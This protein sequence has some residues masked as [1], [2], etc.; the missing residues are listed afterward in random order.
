MLSYS[1]LSG[2]LIGS[3]VGAALIANAGSDVDDTE[4]GEPRVVAGTSLLGSLVGEYLGHRMG[5]TG[6][7]TQ[8]D[9]RIYLQSGFLAANLTS[10]ILASA[11]T[12]EDQTLAILLS[13]AGT[14]GLALG[15]RLVRDHTFTRQEGNLVFL[16]SSAGSLLG[17]GM[18]A[19]LGMGEE[20]A[21]VSQAVG[22]LAGFS[23]TYSIFSQEARDRRTLGGMSS[24]TFDFLHL[25]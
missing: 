23:I 13:G 7:Y 11:D 6:Q 15:R 14:G 21:N 22:S 20:G 9:A 17:L 2:T 1:G 4:P 19:A 24:T 12:W 25:Q 18:A 8:G 5:R 3:G 10:A 16:G